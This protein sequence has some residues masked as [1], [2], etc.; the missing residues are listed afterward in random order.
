MPPKLTKL[1]ATKIST[2][3]Q[4]PKY[5]DFQYNARAQRSFTPVEWEVG[6]IVHQS[7]AQLFNQV[8]D[9]H[10]SVIPR[11]GN[12]KWYEPIVARYETELRASVGAG[13]VKIIRPGQQL[14]LY[15]GQANAA[16]Y[17][18][19]SKVLPG[20]SEQKLLG[21]EEDLGRYLLSGLEI[22][23][24]L[25]L[26]TGLG[27][28]VY[29]HDWKTGKRRPQDERQ[30]RIYYF[31]C[32]AKYGR[33]IVTYRLYHLLEEGDI[34]ET[35]SF[36]PEVKHELEREIKALVERIESMEEFSAKPSTLCH[37]CPF[38]PQCEEGTAFMAEHEVPKHDDLLDL[39]VY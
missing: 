22:S 28:N 6:N 30:A 7:I 33:P 21:I 9:R 12:A 36:S 3:E 2:F 37:W 13:S 10:R 5:Y 20:L 14:V 11:I 39:G 1:S 15:I 26:A 16:L 29:V 31:G 17:A 34:V 32:L 19:T 24:R 35:Y 27:G 25:D 4:C 38:G 18:F 23:G 8:K